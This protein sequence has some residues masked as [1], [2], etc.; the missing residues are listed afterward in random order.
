VLVRHDEKAPVARLLTFLEH[1]ERMANECA[2]AQ[3]TLAP[4]SGSRRFLLSQ[5]RQEA[6]HAVVF[7]GAIAWLAPRHLGCA[8]FLPALEEYREK[9]KDALARQDLLETF[10]AEQVILE[11]LGEVILTRI[12]EGL[13]KRNAP[14]GRLR[15]I[16][17]Q[18][19]EAHHGFGRRMLERA[20]AEGRIDAETLSRSAQGYLALTDRMVL[21]LSDLFE[22]IDEDP[23][24]WARDVWTFLPEWLTRLSQEAISCQ[25]SA[26]VVPEQLRAEC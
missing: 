17:L 12:E 26:T 24:A 7:Q 4:D 9:L 10:L 19:E 14:F 16:L 8:P 15:R 5:A 21:T 22:S 13:V 11:G 6:A 20:M 2:K 23:S 3:A 1:G 18:Q 25:P